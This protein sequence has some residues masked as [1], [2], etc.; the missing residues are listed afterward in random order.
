[1]KE[2]ALQCVNMK[3]HEEVQAYV[4]KQLEKVEEK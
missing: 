2:M 4:T 3:T 1:M